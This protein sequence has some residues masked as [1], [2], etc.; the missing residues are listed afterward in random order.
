MSD[1]R[2]I[3]YLSNERLPAKLACTI[4]QMVMCE[5]FACSGANVTL[6]YPHYFDMPPASAAEIQR[7]YDVEP[8]FDIQRLPSLLSLSKPLVDGRRR[9]KIPFIGGCSIYFSTWRYARNLFRSGKLDASAAIFCRTVTGAQA[10]L[11][12]KHKIARATPFK[13]IF[14][15]HSLDQQTPRR[16]FFEVLKKAD[17][18][19]TVSHAIKK[20]LV[21]DIGIDP[22]KILVASN[23][24]R[25]RLLQAPPLSR[26]EARARLNLPDVPLIVYTGQLLPGKGVHILIE[27]ARFFDSSVQ[28]L[29]VGGHGK[30]FEQMRQWIENEK[31][32]HVKMTGFV[33]PAEIPIYLA[34]ADLLILPT[35]DEHL[36][37][38]YTSPLKLFEY[39]AA[40]RPVVSSDLPVLREILCDGENAL[41]FHAGDADDL[42]AKIK[43]LL[44]DK[45]LAKRLVEQAFH[46]VQDFTWEARAEKILAFVKSLS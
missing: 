1:C 12:L 16:F 38:A 9:L 37:S 18:L 5:A 26:D 3:F 10:F 20:A 39:M 6:L 31:L 44:G 30:Y 33:P 17:G 46:D 27:A 15:V 4:Q 40:C 41:L 23:G 8:I 21:E 14:E 24:V 43:H 19:V 36:D 42:A 28:F 29:V 32:T 13:V 2:N 25:N 11:Q 34:A 22:H 45:K 35:V 7:F